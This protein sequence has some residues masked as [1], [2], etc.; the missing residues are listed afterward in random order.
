M[1]RTYADKTVM[2]FNCISSVS[3]L[4]QPSNRIKIETVS[5]TYRICLNSFLR[6]SCASLVCTSIEDSVETAH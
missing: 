2:R 3:A 4:I 1:P 5:G 6:H